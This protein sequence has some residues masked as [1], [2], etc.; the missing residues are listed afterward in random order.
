MFQPYDASALHEDLDTL[1]VCRTMA[2]L[3]RLGH[4]DVLTNPGSDCTIE[5]DSRDR[6]GQ[7]PLL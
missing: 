2:L 5:A 3:V 7:T 4:D 1:D 6:D